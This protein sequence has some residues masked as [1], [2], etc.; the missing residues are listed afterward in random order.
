MN[1]ID[2]EC[3]W[4][5]TGQSRAQGLDLIYDPRGRI[6]YRCEARANAPSLLRWGR[7]FDSDA[8]RWR[9]RSALMWVG[10]NG[11]EITTFVAQGF[12]PQSQC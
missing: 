8:K 11:L 12:A 6:A 10:A 1:S 4:N 9:F 3:D 7:K 2:V 5:S